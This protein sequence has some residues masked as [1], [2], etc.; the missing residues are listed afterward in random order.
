MAY[1]AYPISNF[2]TGLYDVRDPWL[3]PADGFPEMNNAYIRRGVIRKRKGYSQLGQFS[4]EVGTAITNITQ[5]DP[6]VVTTSAAHGL[7]NGDTVWLYDV[8]GMTEVNGET[9][10]VANVTATTFELSGTD[11]SGFTAYGSAGS[12]GKFV[13]NSITGLGNFVTSTGTETLVATDTKRFCI[14]NSTH[15]EFEDKST[16]DV[17][18]GTASDLMHFANWKDK[19]YMT[20]NVDRIMS[21]DGTTFDSTVD[22]DTD[23]D[24]NN[25]VTDC[26]LIFPYHERLV[27]LRTTEGGTVYPQRARWSKIDDPTVWDE[28][29]TD[30]GGFVDCPTPDWIMGAGFVKDVLVVFFQ[31]SI[32]ILRF[33]GDIDL[34]FRWELVDTNKKT[35]ST[36]SVITHLGQAFAYGD[37]GF[38]GT[39]GLSGFLV[40]NQV[41]DLVRSVNFSNTNVIAAGKYEE[42][43]QA[44]IAT[45]STTASTNDQVFVYNYD[46]KNWAKFDLALTCFGRSKIISKGSWDTETRTWDEIGESWDDYPSIVDEPTFVGGDSSGIIRKLDT[47][48]TD[49]GTAIAFEMKS[50][51]LN[52]FWNQGRRAKLGWIDFLVTS[53]ATTELSVDFYVDFDTGAYQTATLAFSADNG[54]EKVWKR[55]DSGALGSSHRIRLYHTASN[56]PVQIHAIVFN[57]EP[58]GML[59]GR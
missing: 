26:L 16:S 27:L 34:P 58:G 5:A 7:S 46:E 1:Q 43:D 49:N 31:N 52:P 23:G 48:T 3:T 24:T 37:S 44:W 50:A 15:E 36:F 14:F 45:P 59:N 41:P 32:W 2:A 35:D 56:Q 11:T 30:G 53:N 22:I 13:T 17:F 6:G 54:E 47:L 10:T 21:W 18:T 29:I 40:D 38:V 25:D 55:L 51:R 4:H 20:N 39:N 19:I 42:F 8:V 12:V 33:T 57:F 9:Y 28:T